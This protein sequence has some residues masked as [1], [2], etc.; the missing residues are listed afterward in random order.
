LLLFYGEQHA[1]NP[2]AIEVGANLEAPIAQ[3]ATGRHPHR[4]AELDSADIV[5][6]GLAVFGAQPPQPIP[7]GLPTG[8]GPIEGGWQSFH[9]SECTKNGS[10]K[11]SA[12]VGQFDL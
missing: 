5:T 11:L 6:D 1:G 12:V 7:D 10:P 9:A 2:A 4:P 8:G 3:R